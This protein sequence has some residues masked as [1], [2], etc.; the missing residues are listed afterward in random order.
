[1]PRFHLPRP[2]RRQL[3]WLGRWGL[4]SLLAFMPVA[5]NFLDNRY[6]VALQDLYLPVV[7]SVLVALI[8]AL[9][10]K[11]L[12]DRDRLAGLVAS[13]LATLVLATG[14]DARVMTMAPIFKVFMPLGLGGFEGTVYAVFLAAIVHF[15]A[16]WGGKM[17][18]KAV[19]WRGWKPGELAG[20]VL[21]AAVG[22]GVILLTPLISDLIQEWPQF[23][24][25]PP[26]LAAAPGNP[27]TKPDIYYIVLEDYANQDVLKNQFGYDNSGFQN[28]LR[29]QGYTVN[30]NQ[31]ANYPYTAMSVAS[32]LSADYLHDI[33][34]LFGN[35]GKQT[36]VPFN[37][38]IRRAPV[39]T[40][41]Q[42]GGYKYTLVGNWYEGFNL[43]PLADTKYL[44]NGL[45]TVLGH[46]FVLNNFP[47]YQL[48]GSVFGELVMTGLHLGNFAVLGY[49]NQGDADLAHKQ[50]EQ[51]KT[52]A[53]EPAGGR[54][55]VADIL[56]PHEAPFYFNADGSIATNVDEDNVGKP[57]RQKYTDEVQF[58][59][60]QMKSVLKEIDQKSGGKAAVVLLSDEGPQL[61]N[62]T[63]DTFDKGEVSDELQSGNM[64][65]WSRQNLDLKYGTL[66]AFKLPGVD[67]AKITDQTTSSVNIFRL[68]LNSYLGY[69]LPY[70]PDCYFAYHDGR[71]RPDAF[72]SITAKITGQ[73]E[74][75]ACKAGT[76]PDP[77]QK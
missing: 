14:F 21:V 50:L 25:H 64:E 43:S 53:N 49:S 76:T 18:S 55:I 52:L 8:V 47:K 56:V 11:R 75:P 57:L 35:S 42:S 31:K 37:E 3:N 69:N 73:A 13:S 66:A 58:V 60:G 1:M 61:F 51:L 7:L 38:T 23:F 40:A 65:S 46:E 17:A 34:K 28:D 29:D 54:F 41:L 26:K 48:I 19:A 45:F 6:Q 74:D 22:T 62:V 20:G 33:T 9:S 4:L 44:Y 2:D 71:D 24:Y 16:A 68:V 59:N 36:V 30:P 15:L 67:A 77:K 72:T 39:V 12:W 32:T 10:L 63:S 5:S 70:L 27:A